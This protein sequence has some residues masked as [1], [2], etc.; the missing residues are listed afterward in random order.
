ML[1]R[2]LPILSLIAAGVLAW[3]L[4]SNGTLTEIFSPTVATVEAKRDIIEGQHVR[5]TFIKMREIPV[6]D[7][8]NGMITFPKG[9]TAQDAEKSLAN[10]QAGQRITRGQI[11]KST[12]MGKQSSYVVLRS[13]LEIEAGDSI[14]LRN[15]EATNL[16]TAPPRGV[17]VF[18][19][20]DEALSYVNESYDLAARSDLYS[21]QILTINDTA[22]G[23]EK[24]FVVRASQNFRRAESLSIEGLEVTE[25]SSRDLPR[26]AIAFP[27]A[28]AANIFITSADRYVAATSLMRGGFITAEVISSD[29]GLKALP[30]GD[31]PRTMAE[32]AAYMT[33]YP[34]QA[35]IID[36]SVMLDDDPKEKGSIDVWVEDGRTGKAGGLLG[37]IRLK[38]MAHDVPVH[39]VYR[40]EA[41]EM[42]EEEKEGGKSDAP[43]AR[44]TDAAAKGAPAKAKSAPAKK[45]EGAE[46]AEDASGLTYWVKL[47]PEVF[48]EFRR[49]FRNTD[50]VAFLAH[51]GKN[52]VDEIGNG[53]TCIADRCS[54]NRSASDDMSDVL[55]KLTPPD[56][57]A[58]GM[59]AVGG[60]TLTILDTVDAE[61]AARLQ[62]NGYAS[63]A[64]VAAISDAEIQQIALVM[65]I[66]PNRVL[67]IRRQAQMIVATPQAVREE[68]GFDK[69]PA[70]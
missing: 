40:D 58:T 25:I 51:S 22:G 53:A 12:M 64:D 10:Q 42:S 19:T 61:L 69:S 13:T 3:S 63:L 23:A 30:S 27:S 57:E 43:Q 20:Q 32:L 36:A 29:N 44:G 9:T 24:V 7:V 33:A 47:E 66:A 52:L 54:V 14:T 48:R 38:R 35:M 16:T 18:D 17:I 56:A 50:K 37:E 59:G 11:I 70:E 2:L 21:G 45:I 28:N 62:V 46:D 4:W 26:G 34:D 55:A 6:S 8:E 5:A 1:S 41:D 65:N 31:L 60:S 39:V 68:L 15:V 67:F 49:Q